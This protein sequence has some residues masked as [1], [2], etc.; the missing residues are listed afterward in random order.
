MKKL[1][2][3][4]LPFFLVS[5]YK[6]DIDTLKKQVVEL[7]YKFDS[8]SNALTVNTTILQ[9]RADSLSTA[10]SVT[11][12]KISQT[13][14]SIT[15]A[16]KTSDSIS[17]QLKAINTQITTLNGQLATSNAN[18]TSI[19]AQINT[20]IQQ[21]SDLLTK[22]N[23]LLTL[24]NVIN[25]TPIF[26]EAKNFTA[27]WKINWPVKKGSS[28]IIKISGLYSDGGG[29]NN[30]DAAYDLR[31][32]SK[33][34]TCDISI[35]SR[36]RFINKCSLRPDSDKVDSLHTYYYTYTADKDTLS[37]DFKDN[38]YSDNSGSLIFQ[39]FNISSTIISN[40]VVIGDKYARGI[41]AYILQSGDANYDVNVQHGIIS[42]IEDQSQ[43]VQWNSLIDRYDFNLTGAN[44]TKIGTGITNT[45]K[46]LSFYNSPTSTFAAIVARNYN[47]GGFND[48]SLPSKDE[49]Y[50]LYLN[51]SKIGDFN[52]DTLDLL[53]DW[54]WTSSEINAAYAE[55]LNFLTGNFDVIGGYKG[56]GGTTYK[57]RAI[58]YF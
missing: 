28:Y 24:V 56:A 48:W 55:A 3:I 7:Q 21:Y 44:G 31:G 35:Q 6:N 26:S 22:Y 20:L 15:A 30:L 53:S 45:D 39:L 52:T 38:S 5:C 12:S 16:I 25:N 37:F 51:K 42:A 10:L 17:T 40:K 13:S 49:L 23:S 14:L 4:L 46:I 11:N 57:V 43:K 58:R 8:L 54:Y 32:N 34:N 27:A 9:K 1:F 47:G 41:V 33:Y 2:F 19:S 50:K 36:W 18:I 29:A